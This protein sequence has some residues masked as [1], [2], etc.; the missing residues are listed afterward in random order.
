MKKLQEIAHV[1]KKYR[2]QKIEVINGVGKNPAT[3]VEQL[4]QLLIQD[5]V[6]DDEGAAELLGF[7]GKH[8]GNYR[9]VK[10]KLEQQMLSSLFFLDPKHISV[11]KYARL[12]CL[13]DWFAAK[14]LI[15]E[16]RQL[17]GAHLAKK[18]LLKA[19]KYEYEDIAM[20]ICYYLRRYYGINKRDEKLY[21]KYNHLYYK[22]R[23][24]REGKELADEYR[25]MLYN[26]YYNRE[27]A[28]EIFERGNKYYNDLLPYLEK[29]DNLNLHLLAFFIRLLTFGVVYDFNNVLKTAEKAIQFLKEKPLT[30]SIYIGPLY[31]EKLTAHIQLRQFEEGTK[32]AEEAAQYFVKGKHNWDIFQ[33]N[34][35]MLALHTQQ[36]QEAYIVYNERVNDQGLKFLSAHQREMWII[37]EAYIHY[38][39]ELGKI[40]NIDGNKSFANFKSARFINNVPTFSKD[41][42][43]LNIP[44]LIIHFLFLIKNGKYNQA[45]DRL[46]ALEKY[47][48]RYVKKGDHYRSNCFIKLLIKIADANF[49]PVR[50]RRHG[51][52]MLKKLN[53]VPLNFTNQQFEVEIIP[54]E[55]LWELAIESLK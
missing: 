34:K 41:K 27:P 1:L 30:G 14:V 22:Y 26:L 5:K 42:K 44:I 43:G 31:M 15:Y 24:E 20:D 45:I 53:E 8:V 38:L 54:Y 29:H 49:H 10:G 25:I 6:V 4:Y 11:D 7:A 47:T 21:N 23:E 12:K 13:K 48:T 55:Y 50:S 51:A 52:K 17:A 37:F 46:E 33:M 39:L 19:Q 35:F 9:R 28:E 32:T 18:V 36:Y 3:K 16:N 2:A 40:R